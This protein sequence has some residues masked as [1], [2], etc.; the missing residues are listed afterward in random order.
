M[1]NLPHE[2][3]ADTGVVLRSFQIQILIHVI[4]LAIYNGIS[5]EE[6]EEVHEPK[7]GLLALASILRSHF[8]IRTLTIM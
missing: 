2:E 4:Y 8:F 6:V 1:E 7:D 3:N 5:V